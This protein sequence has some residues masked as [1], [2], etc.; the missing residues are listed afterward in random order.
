M[1][2]WEAL[3]DLSLIILMVCALVFISIGL[4]TEGWSK[5]VYDGLGIIFSVFLVV[6]ITAISDYQQ[7]LQSRDL[8]KE[9]KKLFVQVTSDG[10]R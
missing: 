2:I 9:K 4:P 8:D 1:F 3:H 6:T 5:G 7:S 10:K